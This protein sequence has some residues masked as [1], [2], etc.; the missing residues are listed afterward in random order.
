MTPDAIELWWLDQARKETQLKDRLACLN[1]L[2][3]DFRLLSDGFTTEREGGFDSYTKSRRAWAAYGLFFFPQTYA[4]V[5]YIIDEV[6]ERHP[7]LLSAKRPLRV[8]DLGAGTGAATLAVSESLGVEIDATWVDLSSEALALGKQL[9]SSVKSLSVTVSVS[10][11]RQL[12]EGRFDLIVVSYALNEAFGENADDAMK[13]WLDAAISRLDEHGILVICEPVVKTFG[14]RMAKLREWALGDFGCHMIAPCLHDKACPLAAKGEWCHDVRS[15][16]MPWAVQTLNK[17]LNRTLQDIK[18]SFLVLTRQAVA[19]E[20][21]A[22]QARLVEPVR[23]LKGHW[24]MTGCA[25]D[26]QLHRYDLL[27]RNFTADEKEQVRALERG[28]VIR[29]KIER[30]L[31]DGKTLRVTKRDADPSP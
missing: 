8:L 10:D 17:R 1:A 18:F 16:P 30:A 5:R 27:A 14:P 11:L 26:G 13:A 3:E 21:E 31:G 4:R 24:E 22:S 2:E 25:A 6:K 29:V 20:P 28:H 7:S 9:V 15:W 12:P 23:W 19:Q